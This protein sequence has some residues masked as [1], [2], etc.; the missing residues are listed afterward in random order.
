MQILKTL[1]LKNFQCWKRARL[2]FHPG[3][4]VI[5]GSSGR[6]KTSIVRSIAWV[7]KNQGKTASFFPR[8]GGDPKISL[9]GVKRFKSKSKNEYYIPDVEDPL[10][11]F[12]VNPPSEVTAFFG[13]SDIN[14]AMQHDKHFLVSATSGE[15]ARLLNASIDLDVIDISQKKVNSTRLKC[16]GDVKLLKG[17]IQETSEE[18]DQ[19]KDTQNR[20]KRLERLN[21]GVSDIAELTNTSDRLEH[22]IH[23][24]NNL[25]S[26]IKE[27]PD[28]DGA[29]EKIKE[30]FAEMDLIN[31][32]ER[33]QWAISDSLNTLADIEKVL[34]K[35][36]VAEEAESELYV[37]LNIRDDI[38]FLDE[39]IQSYT[40]M[41][42]NF[43]AIDSKIEDLER[44][45]KEE[46]AKLPELCPTCGGPLNE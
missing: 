46:T 37:A 17:Q 10:T 2:N 29:D 32:L 14:W 27:L 3:V 38:K 16:L 36:E 21:R 15:V 25:E 31:S 7:I 44:N 34:K 43:N 1:T 9:N 20:K 40:S 41:I 5:V 26:D 18:L 19:Y 24:Y 4:N 45:I 30:L 13:M 11:A 35:C 23:Q 39:D 22:F 28:T 8:F 42:S 6:G 33:D 12:G